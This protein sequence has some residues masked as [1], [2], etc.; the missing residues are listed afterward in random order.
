MISYTDGDDTKQY[1]KIQ[2][3][4]GDPALCKTILSDVRKLFP[5]YKIPDPVFFKSHPWETGCTYWIP[6]GYSVEFQS[7]AA[8]HPFPAKFPAVWLCG[9]SWSLRQ[10]WVEGALEQ[11][12][13]M[14]EQF[15]F[16][17]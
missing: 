11:T 1:M 2:S 7:K 16:S 14:L 13:K 12:E 8:V 10:A 15:Q 5:A 17:G 4:K 3:E 6:G 9:E